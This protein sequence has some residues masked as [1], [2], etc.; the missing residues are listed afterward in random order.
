MA[1]DSVVRMRESSRS[2][3]G[4]AVP[5]PNT[6]LR[7]VDEPLETSSPRP[8][9]SMDGLQLIGQEL[10]VQRTIHSQGTPSMTQVGRI[11]QQES[12][13]NSAEPTP[14]Q[15][16][17]VSTSRELVGASGILHHQ[18]SEGPIGGAGGGESQLM[19]MPRGSPMSYGPTPSR[20]MQNPL[21][22]FEQLRRLQELQGQA[23]WLYGQFGQ[24]ETPVPRPRNLPDPL[25]E[26]GLIRNRLLGEMNEIRSRIGALESEIQVSTVE[27]RNLADENRNL[28]DENRSLAEENR[29]LRK[30]I[31]EAKEQ[32]ESSS[33][34]ATPEKAFVGSARGSGRSSLVDPEEVQESKEVFDDGYVSKSFE[35]PADEEVLK[36]YEASEGSFFP[37]YVKSVEE[38]YVSKN[39]KADEEPYVS[40]NVKAD[41]EP[42]VPK[43]VKG[44]GERSDGG[45]GAAPG[46]STDQA[47]LQLMAKMMEG[48]TN[49]QR[50]ILENKEKEGDAETVRGQQ[51]LPALPEWS[52]SSGPVDLSDWLAMIEP[53]LADMSSSSARWWKILTKEAGEWYSEHLKLPPIERVSHEASPSEELNQARWTRLERRVSSMLLMAVPQTHSKAAGKSDGVHFDL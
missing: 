44:S 3:D 4:V 7:N 46:S 27:N 1:S 2:V 38:P 35:V 42:Y 24:N 6:P 31:E 49:L 34:F 48:M 13:L 51:E 37:D 39:V 21:F 19:S 33:K 36:N 14:S 29:S 50:Q 23:P 8:N 26:E 47:T 15:Q 43:N 17:M 11:P 52:A 22:D 40:K 5:V 16:E 10:V 45:A 9:G 20:E 12:Q 18:R 32:W 30:K 28:A 25:L 41:E 53:L